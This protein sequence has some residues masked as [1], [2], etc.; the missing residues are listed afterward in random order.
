M[1]SESSARLLDRIPPMISAML[2][3]K[4]STTAARRFFSLIPD[5]E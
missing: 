5:V 4:F 1:A 3:V 2:M